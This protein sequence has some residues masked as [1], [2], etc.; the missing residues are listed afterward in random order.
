M[1][2]HFLF[3]F[4]LLFPLS[5][6]DIFVA[7]SGNNTTGTGT[8]GSPYLSIQKAAMVAVAG[9]VVQVRA[10]TYREQIT[11]TNSGSAGSVITYQPYN[12]EVVT[13]SGADVITGWSAHSGSIYKAAMSGGFM[14]IDYNQTDQIFVDKKMV[15]L[16]RWPNCTSQDPSYPTQSTI[17]NFES[18]TT[19]IPHV[20]KFRDSK[21]PAPVPADKYDGA[22]IYVQPNNMGWSWT[23]S[24]VVTSAFNPSLNQIVMT[25]NSDHGADGNSAIYAFGSRYYMFNKMSLL[26]AAG[27][28]YH[29]KTAQ[30]LYLW[31][32]DNSNP[33]THVVEGKAREYAF[34]LTGKSYITIKGFNL[35]ACSITTDLLLGGGNLDSSV[36]S[37]KRHPYL[38][39]STNIIIDGINAQYLSHFTNVAGHFIYQWGQSSGIVLSNT[40]PEMG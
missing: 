32:P 23:L 14:N 31:C 18:K 3:L 9:D 8:I 37:Y 5:A 12:S 13:I 28:W 21:L 38:S 17:T 20:V 30:L 34:D 27:E 24:G 11:P 16:A 39:A 2:V 25:T 22:E 29:D 19:A 10:G 40:V 4:V 1:L 33:S 15:T 7:P 35:F 26:D 6:K 36:G